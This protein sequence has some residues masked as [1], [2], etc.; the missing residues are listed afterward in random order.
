MNTG[1]F[2]GSFNPL[3][4]GH[5]IIASTVVETTD[6]RHVWFVVS[7]QSPFKQRASL[8]HAFDRYD[9]VARAVADDPRF[10][11]SDVE[12]HLPKPNYTIDTLTY[13]Q[14]KH[15]ERSFTLLMGEDNLT[16]FHKWKNHEQILAHHRLFVYPR[17]GATPGPF[18]DHPK[19]TFVSAPLLDISAT[20]IRRC[21]A[22]HR[23]IR[24][25]VPPE[26][27]AMIAARKFYQ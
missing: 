4:V 1:L 27:E 15:P 2:F 5:L 3:H 18:R 14:E 25:L 10:R 11:V 23:S 8:L 20:F 24:Y 17:P 6:L 7:P 26:V 12:F 19:V 22:E 16:H 9:L 13:L 21:V